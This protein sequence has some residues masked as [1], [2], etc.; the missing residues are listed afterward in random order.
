MKDGFLEY[1]KSSDF[2]IL[3][4]RN[5]KGDLIVPEKVTRIGSFAFFAL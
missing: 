4:G 5:F 3:F 2:E 1:K